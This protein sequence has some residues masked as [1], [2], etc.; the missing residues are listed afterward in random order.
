M[1]YTG[2]DLQRKASCHL[3][4]QLRNPRGS[5]RSQA[6]PSQ[7]KQGS[8]QAR[9][10]NCPGGWQASQSWGVRSLSGLR[11]PRLQ[12]LLGRHY[13]PRLLVRFTRE[14][15]GAWGSPGPPHL[16]WAAS[17]SPTHLAAPNVLPTGTT[18]ALGAQ[19]LAATA[20]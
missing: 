6:K 17:R 1:L 5:S 12:C 15:S 7:A 14:A 2:T 10:P 19:A 4:I 3:E 11:Q 8:K 20:H 13:P 16:H 18:P 9:R